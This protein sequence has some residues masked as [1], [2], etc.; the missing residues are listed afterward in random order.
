MVLTAFSNLTTKLAAMLLD[1]ARD[2][3]S[4]WA[5]AVSPCKDKATSSNNEKTMV[6]NA[7]C[8]ALLFVPLWLEISPRA[9][10]RFLYFVKE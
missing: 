9:T 1:S 5:F 2:C 4:S 6:Q 3:S 10:E 8:K 7:L